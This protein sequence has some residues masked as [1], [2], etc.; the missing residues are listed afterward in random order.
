MTA[1]ITAQP[2]LV[3][4][5]TSPFTPDF[6]AGIAPGRGQGR[7]REGPTALKL[8]VGRALVTYVPAARN[9]CT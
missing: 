2:R 6:S 8:A 4:T 5:S 9:L 3:W 7:R 1:S